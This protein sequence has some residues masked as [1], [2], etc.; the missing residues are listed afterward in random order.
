MLAARF[1]LALP[2]LA[3]AGSLA[4]QKSVPPGPGTLATHIPLFGG[5]LVAVVLVVGALAFLPAL[6]LGPLAEHL[7]L[8]G[9][10]N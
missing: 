5:L 6:A 10:G 2:V 3:L 4:A 1:W 8:Q 9:T 7:M